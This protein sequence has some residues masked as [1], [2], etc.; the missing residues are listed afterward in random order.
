MRRLRSATGSI[1]SGRHILAFTMCRERCANDAFLTSFRA[2]LNMDTRAGKMVFLRLQRFCF[3]WL[4]REYFANFCRLSTNIR[5]VSSAIWTVSTCG[6]VKHVLQASDTLL[7][8]CR[9]NS[10][11]RALVLVI[12]ADLLQELFLGETCVAIALKK[13]QQLVTVSP[14]S[15]QKL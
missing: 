5:Y 13:Q 2:T 9:S 3:R 1:N 8:E 12:T 4:T 11:H 7:Q 15:S 6:N 14:A 10:V